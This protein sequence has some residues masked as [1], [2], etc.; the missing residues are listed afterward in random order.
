MLFINSQA[1]WLSPKFPTKRPEQIQSL[2]VPKSTPALKSS[3]FPAV[4]ACLIVGTFW[5]R[6]VRR[7]TLFAA[8]NLTANRIVSGSTYAEFFRRWYFEHRMTSG[9]LPFRPIGRNRHS[10]FVAFDGIPGS[11]PF[12][13][14][15]FDSMATKTI[16]ARNG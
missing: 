16:F 1:G 2:P 10:D 5:G 15:V 13:D 12:T 7:V 6:G 4:R 14:T 9:T 8:F 3:R 11:F